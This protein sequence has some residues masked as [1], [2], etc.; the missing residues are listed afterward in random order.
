[1]KNMKIKKEN[2]FLVIKVMFLSL[3]LLSYQEGSTQCTS[4]YTSGDLTIS[5]T[6][7]ISSDI[8]I[9][10][11][12]KFSSDATLVINS[13][14]IVTVTGD[15]E[16]G[17]WPGGTYTISGGGTLNVAGRFYNNIYQKSLT[18]SDLTVNVDNNGGT[19]ESKNEYGSI[20]NLE[21]GTLFTVTN[22]NFVNGNSA[23]LTIDNSTMIISSGNYKNDSGSSTT[24]Q[25]EGSLIVS[26]G[27]L[28][29]EGAS[30]LMVDNSTVNISNDF[31]NS[32]QAQLDIV[33]NSTFTIGGVFDNGYDTYGNPVN[34]GYINV[35][36]S[37]LNVGYFNNA[38]AS[39][40]DIDGGGVV[41]VTNDLLNDYGAS[42][43][44]PDG[45]LVVGGTITDNNNGINA[46][47]SDGC[48][49][50]GCGALPVTVID[51]GYQLV[52]NHV[53]LKW[54]TASELNNDYF[55]IEKSTDG[56]SFAKVGVVDGAGT[57]YMATGYQWKDE[58]QLQGISYYR[59]KQTD[60][61]GSYSYQKTIKI[62]PGHATSEFRIMPNPVSQE[63]FIYVYG[64]GEERATWKIQTI[65]G[66]VLNEGVFF[67]QPAVVSTSGLSEGAYILDFQSDK[68]QKQVKII[69]K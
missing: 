15:F 34:E 24:V 27:D 69:V 50:N 4:G 2:S 37:N 64:I 68:Q 5:G 36:G 65:N 26:D 14:V 28:T 6:C 25:N 11:A 16:T 54:R 49:G 44:I 42:I 60:F 47:C 19:S 17:V 12:L 53:V 9:T 23:E 22:G 1:M 58:I 7:T 10:G 55:S 32:F 33:N 48:C 41:T 63:D 66:Q 52:N 31:N 45:T 38:F 21:N 57:S 39:N 13:G 3:F 51:M 46:T 61:D 30:Q 18:I 56:K 40:M 8:T 67:G 62:D 20:F 59:L 43:D 35:N 29:T